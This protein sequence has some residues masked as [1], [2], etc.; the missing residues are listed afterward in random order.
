MF[1][2]PEGGA[3]GEEGAEMWRQN[4][5]TVLPYISMDPPAPIDCAALAA[6]RAPTLVVQGEQSWTRL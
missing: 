5:R 1:E 2:L 6:I 4:G 3:E